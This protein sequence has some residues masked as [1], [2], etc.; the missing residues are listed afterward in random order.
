MIAC[1]Q[2]HPLAWRRLL[3]PSDIAKYP[4]IAPPTSSP[5][6][7]DLRLAPANIGAD[8]FKISFSGG[9][10]ASVISVLTGSDSLTVLPYS[11]VFMMREQ[12]I[13]AA[14]SLKIG[15]PD[16]KLGL[17]VPSGIDRNPATARL[18][19]FIISQ[20]GSFTRRIVQHQTEQLWRQQVPAVPE[21]E[22]RFS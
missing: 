15:H 2:G 22:I 17:L 8:D 18:R 13:L 3:I 21:Q 20:F 9:S 5:L 19:R 12:S 11:V 14:L 7:R 16:R 4:W 1:R 10:L 6:Y